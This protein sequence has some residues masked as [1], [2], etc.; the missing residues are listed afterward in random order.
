MAADRGLRGQ[1]PGNCHDRTDET[2]RIDG[3]DGMDGT[4]PIDTANGTAGR[5]RPAARRWRQGGAIRHHVSTQEESKESNERCCPGRN[6][7]AF[8]WIGWLSLTDGRGET[9]VFR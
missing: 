7:A 4:D 3:T 9:Q 1:G 5:D 2:D 6:A 8:E